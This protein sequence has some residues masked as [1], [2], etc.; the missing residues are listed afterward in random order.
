MPPTERTTLRRTL[1]SRIALVLGTL[2][3]IA[4]SAQ[5]A[6]TLGFV[7]HWS[8]DTLHAWGGG[9]VYANPGAGGFLGAGDG[10]LRFSTP[11]GVQ[12]KLG[13]RS[14]GAEFVVDLSS[15]ANWTHHIGLGTFDQALQNITSIPMRHD[16]APFVQPPDDIEADV[17][18]DR[19][20]LTNGVVGVGPDGPAVAN[21]VRLAAPY[22]NPSPGP[23]AFSLEVVDGG[24]VTLEIVDALCRRATTGY[25]QPARPEG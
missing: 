6:P 10:Y 15:A 23:V 25:A 1:C 18:L 12:N 14:F 2:F 4:G 7:E 17:G 20:L 22:P 21:P 24:A 16:R 19:V 13:A 9:A 8:G 3:V 11:N 5:A